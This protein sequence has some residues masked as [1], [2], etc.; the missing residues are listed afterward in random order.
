MYN[1]KPGDKAIIVN[2]ANGPSGLSVGRRVRVHANAPTDKG[3]FDA[4]WSD[5]ANSLNDPFHYC[6]PT[7]YEKEHTKLGKIW[8]V[9]CI[10]GGTFASEHGGVGLAYVDVP[11]KWLQKI[12]EPP[13]EPKE[14]ERTADRGEAA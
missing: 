10:N 12:E 8:P 3:E 4:K 2:S 7:P 9:T 11:D 5:A 13:A 6:P 1:V 14:L